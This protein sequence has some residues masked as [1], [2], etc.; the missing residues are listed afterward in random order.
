MTTAAAMADGEA[1]LSSR[2]TRWCREARGKA[3]MDAVEDG[4]EVWHEGKGQIGAGIEAEPTRQPATE[5][6]PTAI[7]RWL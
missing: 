4:P 5:R 2:G 6:R 7:T 1:I 3:D